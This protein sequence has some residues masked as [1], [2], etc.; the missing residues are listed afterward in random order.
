MRRQVVE[1][2]CSRCSRIERKPPSGSESDLGQGEAF[3]AVLFL[4]GEAA[5]R[6]SFPELCTPC[7]KTVRHHLEAIA[8]SIKGA[9]PNRQAAPKTAEEL[10]GTSDIL[11]LGAKKKAQGGPELSS[12]ST[13][14]DRPPY[15][16]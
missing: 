8:K 11:E 13:V 6:V 3:E 5:V 14:G 15:R 7:M 16:S 9:S 12:R 2:A 4:E 10:V 1:I